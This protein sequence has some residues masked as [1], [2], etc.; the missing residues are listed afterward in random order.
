[1]LPSNRI[2]II[3]HYS[4]K[5][6][7]TATTLCWFTMLVL[8]TLL[9]IAT[10][11]AAAYPSSQPPPFYTDQLQHCSLQRT[12]QGAFITF[13]LLSATFGTDAAFVTGTI[14]MGSRSA[15]LISSQP[16][17]LDGR[18]GS[19]V[20]DNGTIVTA[21]NLPPGATCGDY[22]FLCAPNG[23]TNDF[24]SD[25]YKLPVTNKTCANCSALPFLILRIEMNK[26]FYAECGYP[27]SLVC[28]AQSPLKQ[29]SQYTYAAADSAA[30]A[31][32]YGDRWAQATWGGNA[33]V[34]P[35][36]PASSYFVAMQGPMT[37]LP[38]IV[39]EPT[40][41]QSAPL[42]IGN[43]KSSNATM[44]TLYNLG[45][46]TSTRSVPP[47]VAIPDV[48]PVCDGPVAKG[49]TT[50]DM[51]TSN[52]QFDTS[53]VGFTTKLNADG[54]TVVDC[55]MQRAL[56]GFGNVDKG[57]PYRRMF[58]EKV[59][60]L[61]CATTVGANGTVSIK[62]VVSTPIG[63]RYDVYV[64]D[65]F[66]TSCAVS[67]NRNQCGNFLTCGTLSVVT[68]A[69]IRVV[70]NERFFDTSC[71]YAARVLMQFQPATLPSTFVSPALPI[72]P[73]NIASLLA[74]Y[75]HIRT[76]SY[77][78]ATSITAGMLYVNNVGHVYVRVLQ[79]GYDCS[80][81]TKPS[82]VVEFF[83]DIRST[84][85]LYACGGNLSFAA[86]MSGVSN[87]C[88]LGF[89]CMLSP[90]EKNDPLSPGYIKISG[91]FG[92]VQTKAKNQGCSAVT[93][94]IWAR[95]SSIQETGAA[96]LASP[97]Q[98]APVS[99]CL[100]GI[101][102]SFFKVGILDERNLPASSFLNS[103]LANDTGASGAA[104][105]M[106]SDFQ[107]REGIIGVKGAVYDL[108]Y[109]RLLSSFSTQLASEMTQ[110][111]ILDFIG[112]A[113]GYCRFTIPPS[114]THIDLQVEN[115]NYLPTFNRL[116]VRITDSANGV[117]EQAR[118][119]GGNRGFASG[120]AA[121]GS[122]MSFVHCINETVRDPF[123]NLSFRSVSVFVP[124]S[125]GYS[126]PCLHAAVLKAVF[127]YEP[128][129]LTT[130]TEAQTKC[131]ATNGFYCRPRSGYVTDYQ[132]LNISKLCDGTRDCYY[133]NDETSCAAFEMVEYNM[134]PTH[135][136]QSVVIPLTPTAFDCQRLAI[137]R[138][139][140]LF[141]H[142]PDTQ[143]CTVFTNASQIAS[144]IA[145]PNTS[146][147]LGV[148][149]SAKLATRLEYGR[150]SSSFSCFGHGKVFATSSVDSTT[151]C[152]CLCT[153]P[154]TGPT[155]DH[156]N[157]VGTEQA[158]AIR[159]SANFSTI[160]YQYAFSFVVFGAK[161]LGLIG[162]SSLAVSCTPFFME[163]QGSTNSVT[164]ICSITSGHI[165]STASSADLTRIFNSTV[166]LWMRALETA[167]VFA[168]PSPGITVISS[169]CT[170]N[171]ATLF[172]ECGFFQPQA[173]SSVIASAS[174][175]VPGQLKI[176]M[177]V[178]LPPQASTSSSRRV[179]MVASNDPQTIELTC[180]QIP[181]YV[182]SSCY[183]SSCIATVPDGA[184]VYTAS[185][186][187]VDSTSN[188][189]I[190]SNK[191][192]ATPTLSFNTEPFHMAGTTSG[193]M[194]DGSSSSHVIHNWESDSTPYWVSSIVI[195]LTILFLIIL[196]AGFRHAHAT[197]AKMEAFRRSGADSADQVTSQASEDGCASDDELLN[198]VDDIKISTRDDKLRFAR[199]ASC[200][201]TLMVVAIIM[202]TLSAVLV[203]M[204]TITTFKSNT[205]VIIERY[206]TGSCDQDV[207]SPSPVGAFVVQD[208]FGKC[209]NRE[210][211]G[212]VSAL[213]PYMSAY[214][215]Y[216]SSNGDVMVVVRSAF[217]EEACNNGEVPEVI[218]RAG[219]CV[220]VNSLWRTVDDGT[221]LIARCGSFEDIGRRYDSLCGVGIVRPF[222]NLT[223]TATST[224][225]ASA[226]RNH[227]TP[228]PSSGLILQVA[229]W[230]TVHLQT[231]SSSAQRFIVVLYDST[232]GY[233]FKT[234]TS[235]FVDAALV[236]S[237]VV[238]FV[239]ESF[240][241]PS[242]P[243]Y[244][245]VSAAL[246]AQDRLKLLT[247]ENVRHVRPYAQKQV[248]FPVGYI[249]GD[250]NTSL[251]ATGDAAQV[252]SQWYYNAASNPVLDV[253]TVFNAERKDGLTGV[254]VSFHLQATSDS[255][256]FAFAVAD[257]Y[258]NSAQLSPL[259]TRLY[260]VIV[261]SKSSAWW[262]QRTFNVYLAV[263]INGPRKQLSVVQAHAALD[264]HGFPVNP[265]TSASEVSVI[266]FN[267]EEIGHE[268]LY[269]GAWH[270]IDFFFKNFNSGRQELQLIIDGKTAENT[271]WVKCMKCA[272]R[273]IAQIPPGTS[274]PVASAG[275]QFVVDGV[276]IAG[277]LNGGVQGLDIVPGIRDV[278]ELRLDSSPAIQQRTEMSV[279]GLVSLGWL[280]V[281]I[282]LAA[283]VYFCGAAAIA[284]R[285]I[286]RADW[287]N[288]FTAA[289]LTYSRL[290]SQATYRFVPTCAGAMRLLTGG[291]ELE[292]FLSVLDQVKRTCDG[293]D[294]QA[295]NLLITIIYHKHRNPLINGEDGTQPLSQ[296][297]PSAT[298]LVPPTLDEWDIYVTDEI[299]RQVELI[300]RGAYIP[301]PFRWLWEAT[302]FTELG[303]EETELNV[304]SPQAFVDN[305]NN[306]QHAS[307]ELTEVEVLVRA[308]ND[309]DTQVADELRAQRGRGPT[310]TGGG[311]AMRTAVLE[312]NTGAAGTTSGDANAIETAGPIVQQSLSS[313]VSVTIIIAALVMALQNVF[314][315]MEKFSLPRIYLEWFFRLG[316]VVSAELNDIFPRIDPLA[317]TY[318]MLGLGL[319]LAGLGTLL[320]FI[321]RSEFLVYFV[322]YVLQRDP[323]DYAMRCRRLALI[324]PFRQTNPLDPGSPT[325]HQDWP[326]TSEVHATLWPW[327]SLSIRK[328]CRDAV[329]AHYKTIDQGGRAM[330]TV[331]TGLTAI[332]VPRDI[333][334]QMDNDH[335]ADDDVTFQFPVQVDGP[336]GTTT[337]LTISAVKVRGTADRFTFHDDRGVSYR[338]VESEQHCPLH[339]DQALGS[340]FQTEAFP[341]HNRIKCCLCIDGSLCKCDG[342][343]MRSCGK[344]VLMNG[345]MYTCQ[346]AVCDR[347]FKCT[348]REAI[349]SDIIGYLRRAY[350]RGVLHMLSFVVFVLANAM[351]TPIV[352]R[353]MMVVWCHISMHCALGGCKMDDKSYVAGYVVAIFVLVLY[354]LGY[355]VA[356]LVQLTDRQKQVW[357]IFFGSQY[358][359]MYCKHS[360]QRRMENSAPVTPNP[361]RP[362]TP[363]DTASETSSQNSRFS[364]VSVSGVGGWIAKLF[365]MKVLSNREWVRFVSTDTSAASYLYRIVSYE[366]MVFMPMMLLFRAVIVVTIVMSFSDPFMSHAIVAAA[367]VGFMLLLCW[368][369]FVSPMV[370]LVYRLGSVHQLLVF[371]MHCLDVVHRYEHGKTKFGTWMVCVTL[372]YILF[373]VA[374]FIHAILWTPLNR[375]RNRVRRAALLKGIGLR[376]NYGV[377]PVTIVRCDVAV[378]VDTILPHFDA[379]QQPQ[380]S[381]A[382]EEQLP[383]HEARDGFQEEEAA[384][385]EL[386]V[387]E[388]QHNEAHGL[389][390]GVV[391]NSD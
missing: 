56:P 110:I 137:I 74:G 24:T 340:S 201:C 28:T 165:S 1:M 65:V 87:Q 89:L 321:D 149:I 193:T 5:S 124:A 252:S 210:A 143:I 288:Q 170:T 19:Y 135:P 101:D 356:S 4:P 90:L 273:S 72:I 234:S 75:T 306:T 16:L 354:G 41:N 93:F 42:L 334:T 181:N 33:T 279:E 284:H 360:T 332:A 348:L 114:A 302:H 47:G 286:R 129:N 253:G 108:T 333:A 7:S 69:T 222:Q 262:Y 220:P 131:A 355:P 313:P 322:Q 250:F 133:G 326:Q 206:N 122:C 147:M 317:T 265:D 52:C 214:C 29:V 255:V 112:S 295:M 18:C 305:N 150:C 174:A 25:R 123:G 281:S 217:N 243:Y 179:M 383:S 242:P 379:P 107:Q 266:T 194:I 229:R 54:L 249:F 98:L 84:P 144:F 276:L 31:D 102:G 388:E 371:G 140:T 111:C 269:N 357:N 239:N 319:L 320:Q 68:N 139:T 345:K 23:T 99:G 211:V 282:A 223:E 204:T 34:S 120:S 80:T 62:V 21:M 335:G 182:Q 352:R 296:D 289:T 88:N 245:P 61:E 323:V 6:V 198:V 241:A 152:A 171:S 159:A 73:Y 44:C 324:A 145:A 161:N 386:S 58:F 121:S 195:T 77:S 187:F 202:V 312:S 338:V 14:Q 15:S 60:S 315:W 83:N 336:D 225:V 146:A 327:G 37:V 297:S 9:A 349:Q 86:N 219:S 132:C 192:C 63:G 294:R 157:V 344:T 207:L 39:D 134:Q 285:R 71:G 76:V 238:Q 50:L 208:R 325:S 246:D 365:N 197:D 209:I 347:H 343:Q 104:P 215:R 130:I 376:S 300:Q 382:P 22:L 270:R 231:L 30:V 199:R 203:W 126:Q 254:T 49:W 67:L 64:N 350:N 268:F 59:P 277:A 247:E 271:D 310:T 175:M 97:A 224:T 45:S 230:G 367:E 142:S 374:C 164:T 158:F 128:S 169:N 303:F 364:A 11:G 361:T 233:A 188:V 213:S 167:Q 318:F 92:T 12:T 186:G 10:R 35:A 359:M 106:P 316:A 228:D 389:L 251:A 272:V 27:M 153:E 43:N 280:L 346:Y 117:T 260:D 232:T 109:G 95:N 248:E 218:V 290:A 212:G 387:V 205:G 32:G 293:S 155:C 113:G 337:T 366:F 148:F 375:W 177:S 226:Y 185:I 17:T 353:A 190:P 261:N 100:E 151:H 78:G 311:R 236:T 307:E 200:G 3:H 358:G 125:V 154:Y 259:L 91:D 390:I 118:Q 160:S 40:F 373:C 183:V 278:Y 342:G 309:E 168:L 136:M 369:G 79:S 257:G 163:N 36:E 178:S 115:S 191:I 291:S 314:M 103:I 48:V 267:L 308:G 119:C 372:V 13:P 351:Y 283:L 363:G 221:F 26:L 292:S 339:T 81:C 331:F 127:R 20:A 330:Q 105:L 384:G 275:D 57:V 227:W 94:E 82:I 304:L 85:Q 156:A 8:F 274:V 237:Y 173:I 240:G 189:S 244:L 51:L 46:F 196:G 141:M 180:S 391:P 162:G 166:S 258:A 298:T 287:R 362:T 329:R 256:G 184:L 116:L 385:Q 368:G 53:C 377:K 216:D 138:S 301:M 328:I 66:A 38:Y 176:F 70:P 263:F 299:H 341:L 55:L 381:V 380:T 370:E 172:T 378:P 96:P 2:T 264:V 235:L